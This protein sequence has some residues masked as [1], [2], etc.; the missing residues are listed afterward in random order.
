MENNRIAI[1]QLGLLKVAGTDAKKFLQGQLT[2][3]LT[4]VDH[5]GPQLAAFCQPQGRVIALFYLFKHEEAYYL[6][7]PRSMLSLTIAA[8]KKY[9]IFFKV[10]LSEAD[11]HWKIFDASN[12]CSPSNDSIIIR[13]SEARYIHIDRSHDHA[14]TTHDSNEEWHLAT[15]RAGIP[16]IHPETSGKFLPHDLN[17]HQL[18]AISFNKGCYTGQEIIARMHYRGKLKNHL[19]HA[20]L[21][22]TSPPILGADIYYSNGNDARTCG[23][24]VD[25]AVTTT[26]EYEM[27]AIIE[28]SHAKNEHLYLDPVNPTAFLQLQE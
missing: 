14:T 10:T 8:L 27:L 18:N 1:P 21:S 13:M 24:V 3:D 5:N 6:L 11:T 7:L 15:I 26:G 16:T 12:D 25:A 20:T 9:A 23:N 2:C 19:Y 28:E 4:D 22:T 17:L